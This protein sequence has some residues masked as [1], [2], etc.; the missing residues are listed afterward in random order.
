LEKGETTIL[1]VGDAHKMT[2]LICEKPQ[3]KVGRG[4]SGLN[5]QEQGRGWASKEESLF[6]RARSKKSL[7]RGRKDANIGGA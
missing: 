6:I 4:I 3:L 5:G 1:A 7:T 2:V